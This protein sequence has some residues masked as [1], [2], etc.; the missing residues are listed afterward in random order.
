VTDSRTRLVGAASV[1]SLVLAVLLGLVFDPTVRILPVRARLSDLGRPG[2]A[3][4]FPFDYGLV[5]AG[6]FGLVAVRAWWEAAPDRHDRVTTTLAGVAFT[7][8]ALAGLFPAP[9]VAHLPALAAAYLAGWTAP[10]LDGF[11]LRRAG[12]GDDDRSRAG[13]LLVGGAALVAVL[14]VVRALVATTFVLSGPT[15]AL[16]LAELATLALFAGWVLFRAG[17]GH[18]ALGGSATDGG[19]SAGGR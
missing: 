9:S 5:L 7:G 8:L 17:V 18:A 14:W 3:G 10:L 15:S 16:L 1:A 4:A 11:G 2:G 19:V 12:A 13:L 6:L